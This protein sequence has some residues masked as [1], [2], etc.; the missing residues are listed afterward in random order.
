MK[1]RNLSLLL[2]IIL[3]ISTFPPGIFAEEIQP[4]AIVAIEEDFSEDEFNIMQTNED[5]FQFNEST[6]T[7][8]YYFGTYHNIAI[9]ETIRGVKV[10]KV[11]N[12][13][14]SDLNLKNVIMPDSITDIGEGAFSRN[15]LKNVVISDNVV[16]IGTA[17][18]KDNQLTSIN[19]PKGVTEISESAFFNNQLKNVT[20]SGNV[21]SIGRS[22]FTANQLTSIDI[23]ESVTRIEHF[24]FESNKL[25]NVVIPDGVTIIENYVFA[26]NQLT[27]V[28]IPNGVTSIGSG[29]FQGN[30]LTDVIIP[31]SV[32]EIGYRAF[33]NNPLRYISIPGNTTE[34]FNSD[35]TI[36]SS[37]VIITEEGSA[38]HTWAAGKGRSVQL[39][40][41]TITFDLKGGQGYFPSHTVELGESLVEP[42]TTPTKEGAIFKYWRTNKGDVFDFRTITED[43]TIFAEWEETIPED[44]PFVFDKSTGTITGYTGTEV[45]VVIPSKIQGVSVLKIGD[46]AFKEKQLQSVVI[47]NSVTSIGNFAFLGNQLLSIDIPDSVNSIGGHAFQ[48][49]QL[50]KV[51]LPNNMNRINQYTFAGNQL[52]RINIPD[53]VIKIDEM[54]FYMNP[55]EYI[56]ISSNTDMIGGEAIPSS[57]IIITEENSTA[58]TWAINNSRSVQLAGR[59]A[60]FDLKGGE[61]NFSPH[62]VKLGEPLVKPNA[63]PKKEG[64][65]FKNWRTNIEPVYDFRTI[66]EDIVIYPEWEETIPD[67]STIIVNHIDIDTKKVLDTEILTDGEETY[68]I[69]FGKIAGY[70]LVDSSLNLTAKDKTII[71]E[72]KYR[73][74][75]MAPA[76]ATIQIHHIDVNTNDVLETETLTK[77]LGTYKVNSKEIPG[78]TLADD[79][80]KEITLTIKDEVVTVEFNY[81]KDPTIESVESLADIEVAYGTERSS[82]ALPSTVQ[83]R[84][85]DQTNRSLGVTWDNG[86][87][88]YNGNTASVYTFTGTLAQDV[89]NPQGLT[90]EVKVIV[91]PR[92]AEPPVVSSVESL[93]D[94]EVAYGTERSALPL[95]PTVQVRLSDQTNRSLG[96]TWD[97]GSPAYNGNTAGEYRFTGTLAQ[98][99]SNPQGLTAEVKVVVH[100]K[101]AEPPV[102]SSVESLDDIEVA[103]GTERSALPLQPTVQVRL[104][105]QTS[106]SL[107]VTWDGGS[108]VYN[109]NTAG[110]YTFTGTLAQDVS[111]PQ[112]LTAEVKVIVKPRPA[113]PPVVLSVG[114]LDDIEVAYGT[115]RSALPLPPT[116][117]VMLSDQTN[118]SLG[119]TWDNGSP[120]YNGNT[121]GEYTF[122]GS[123]AQDVSNPQGL[124]AEVKVIVKPRPAEPPVVSSVESLDDIEV[125]YGTER[126]ALPLPPTVQVRLSDQTSQSLGVTWDDGSPAYNGNTAEEYR[127]TGTLA[128]DVPNPQGLTAE[129]KVVVRP[130]EP[131]PKSPIWP[132]GSELTVSDITKTSVKLSWPEAQDTNGVI[133]Y[134]IYVDSREAQTVTGSV[135]EQT[136]T[137][138]IEGTTYTFTVMAFNAAGNESEPLSAKAMIDRSSSGGGGGGGNSG[139]EG[140]G[141]GSGGGRALSSNA[142]LEEL[143]V[144]AKEM[145]L[146]LSPYFT[147]ATTS[148]TTRTEAEQVEITV[149]PAH[150]AAKVMLKDQVITDKTKV[151][152]EEGGNKLVLVI[153]AEN[154][155]KKEYT[156][157]IH[158]ETPKPSEPEIH[159]SDI[160]GHWAESYVKRSAAKGIVSGYPDGTFKPSRSVTRAE[161]TVMLFSALQLEEDDTTLTFIDQD[162]IGTWAKQTVAKAVKAGIVSGYGDGSFRPNG[163]ITRAEMAVMIARALKLPRKANIVTGFADDEEIPEWAKGSVEV[164]RELG[165]TSGREGNRFVPNDKA[166]RA[167]ATAMLIRMLERKENQ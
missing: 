84:L 1:K 36:P 100:P 29:A 42:K 128:Q 127:F 56:S 38:A 104:S 18:F 106:Q 12:Y 2:T 86:N 124:T 113:E 94:I 164:I 26:D 69:N 50:A 126:S 158:R 40:G 163:L 166:T 3:L 83:V 123:L 97:D 89:S 102:V 65:T 135:Y 44:S 4:E 68:A 80:S 13:G 90:A 5:L 149:K 93:D 74:E 31:D 21:T 81:V 96:V 110:E 9:P 107:G 77:E 151:H 64:A 160:V 119:L 103:Y 114:S 54:A 155:N 34:I 43:I 22:A 105:D 66:T 41:K 115:E 59:T 48:A 37:A 108:P 28:F 125:A 159:F 144:W 117:Q 8:E 157:N 92:P 150:S 129:V 85:S 17:A 39:V 79:A 152:L 153:Q 76:T 122:T 58:H 167:E 46:N 14:F 11:K 136:V 143:H 98:D 24:A 61:G 161:F 51:I 91:K 23:P 47:P 120:V 27:D 60:S 146:G 35:D 137:G 118:R 147:S 82:L 109:G 112:G 52:K 45:N 6:G 71:L 15:Q 140:P 165:I 88:A 57:S 141:S 111:N 73:K 95:P 19:I 101:P 139:G 133:G 30:Q 154:G 134:R 16:N 116:V 131:D 75:P 99:V 142:D 132:N 67:P 87:P 121:A 72:F 33:Y 55:L 7:V 162:Q 145:K 10:V 53:S 78:Y 138:L 130:S 20:I 63:I 148:Y 62:T 49:N 70:T 32:T 156:L 25:T